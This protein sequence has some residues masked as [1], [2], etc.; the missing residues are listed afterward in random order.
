MPNIP[1]W[2]QSNSNI[3]NVQ[4]GS[5]GASRDAFVVGARIGRPTFIVDEQVRRSLS[6]GSGTQVAFFDHFIGNIGAASVPAPWSEDAGSTGT[7]LPKGTAG[8]DGGQLELTTAAAAANDHITLALGTHWT[9]GAGDGGW[10]FFEASVQLD[11]LTES[12]LEVGLSDALSESAGLTFSDHSV[13]GVTDVATDAV[14][15]AYDSA[16][17]ANW[18]VNT[19]N[20]GTPSAADT[21]VAATTDAIT[22]RFDISPTGDAYFYI[23][24]DL[25]ATIEDA[26][27]ADVALGPWVSLVTLGTSASTASIDYIGVVGDN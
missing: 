2:K 21:G 15:F 24:N 1:D 16:V 27:A 13:A 20:N 19:A 3:A 14:V 23:A 10:I 7:A 11:Q 22:L 17:G 18:L 4:G 12:V 6:L 25:V 5:L 9:V 8:L 26:V